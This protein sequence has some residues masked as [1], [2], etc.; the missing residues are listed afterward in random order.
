MGFHLA[1]SAVLII[2]TAFVIFVVL[3]ALLAL[4]WPKVVYFHI[5]AVL[6]GAMIEFTGAICPLTPLE[7]RLRQLGGGAGYRGDFID[8]YLVSILYPSG[9]TR[10]VQIAL[11]FAALLPNVLVYGYL[12]ARRKRLA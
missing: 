1:A 4:R 8:H 6:W 2:H 5:P 10:G 9:L 11:G 3:G 7:V 12:L